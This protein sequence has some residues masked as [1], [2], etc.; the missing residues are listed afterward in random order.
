MKKTI[1]YQVIF[2]ACLLF[3]ACTDESSNNVIN[4]T[5]IATPTTTTPNSYEELIANFSCNTNS[6]G[7]VVYI[8]SENASYSC[9]F[10]SYSNQ[11][12]WLLVQEFPSTYQQNPNDTQTNTDSIVN[13]Q[14]MNLPVILGTMVDPRD[15]AIYQT[16]TIG[17]QTWMT[18]NLDYGGYYKKIYSVEDVQKACKGL[19]GEDCSSKK[20]NEEQISEGCHYNT[21]RCYGD[22]GRLLKKCRCG[23]SNG[24]GTYYT[25]MEATNVNCNYGDKTCTSPTTVQGVCPDGWHIPSKKEWNLLKSMLAGDSVNGAKLTYAIGDVLQ[26]VYGFAPSTYGGGCILSGWDVERGKGCSW[27]MSPISFWLSDSP[28]WL[29]SY[30]TFDA[31]IVFNYYSGFGENA[32]INES[33]SVRCVKD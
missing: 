16:T 1:I 12:I 33:R 20:W 3:Y 22:V 13:Y 17:S 23:N 21:G 5:N 27:S 30:R 11:W 18:E 24:Y 14:L 26:N 31:S 7:T 4:N 2:F 9:S 8:A 28:K 29:N 19:S 6:F 15:S 25:W 32:F 10:D